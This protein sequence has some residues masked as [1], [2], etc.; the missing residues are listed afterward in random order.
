MSAP[1]VIGLLG[2]MSW[3]STALY[4]A[5]LNQAFSRHLGGVHSAPMLIDSFDFH[6]VRQLQLEQRWEQAGELLALHATRLQDAGAGMVAL[7]VNT[8]HRVADAVRAAI[9]VPFVDIREC[10]VAH[11][12][13]RKLKRPLLLGG[14]SVLEHRG[15]YTEYLRERGI[16]PTLPSPPQQ[17]QLDHIIFE[18]FPRQIFSTQALAFCR[19]LC[20]AAQAAGEADCVL[21]ACTELPIL[22]KPLLTAQASRQGLPALGAA[23]PMPLIDTVECHVAALTALS[24]GT[25]ASRAGH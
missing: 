15:F 4:Y 6:Q 11:L 9:D 22:M 2:G 3:E 10:A 21:L 13:D 20:E 5:R 8:M 7:A 24:L 1:L 18:E 23:N 25:T 19:Q 16:E 14:S 12:E 17:R